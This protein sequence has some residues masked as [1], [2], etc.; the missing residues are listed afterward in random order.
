MDPF[1]DKETL[2]MKCLQFSVIL[3][4][5]LNVSGCKPSAPFVHIPISEST[6]ININQKEFPFSK[7][8][9]PSKQV[10]EVCFYYSEFLKVN[11]ITKPPQFADGTPLIITAYIVDQNNENLK[12]NSI[13][14]NGDNL[15]CLRP[16][17]FKYWIDIS[18][19]NTTFVKLLVQ[20]NR[21]ITFSKIEWKTYNAWDFK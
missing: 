20:T 10:N 1:R 9:K 8:F 19:K 18:K 2:Q 16:E 5:I 7:P 14:R 21:E 17:N 15:L 3:F 4:I 12:L 13:T 11:E 6:V